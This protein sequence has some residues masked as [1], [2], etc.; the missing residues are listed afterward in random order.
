ML[1]AK[2][3]LS[4]LVAALYDAAADS[5]LW[6]AFLREVALA[7]QST[8]AGILLHDLQHG[9]HSISLQWGIDPSAIRS[10]AEYYGKCDLWVRKAAPLV[11]T[12]WLG[13]S[14]EACSSQEL[15]RTEFYNDYLKSMDVGQAMW[16]VIENSQSRMISLGLYRDLRRPFRSKDLDLLRFLAP[17]LERAFRLHLKFTELRT[18]A[19]DMQHA[20]D[21]F[22]TGIIFLG[23]I[24]ALFT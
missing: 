10:Y 5:S 9:D 21:M 20:I 1:P 7:T 15:L 23:R 13:T 11:H 12:G 6:P 18:R 22:S 4:T 17:H 2:T 19:E 16:G 24:P 3:V 8:Q 14:E